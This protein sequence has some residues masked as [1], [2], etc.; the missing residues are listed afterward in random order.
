MAGRLGAR[1]DV[2]NA[3]STLLID[4]RIATK[5]AGISPVCGQVPA[6]LRIA[7]VIAMSSPQLAC[8][9]GHKGQTNSRAGA[10]PMTTN[11]GGMRLRLAAVQHVVIAART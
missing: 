5:R 6:V 2:I 1:P 3:N 10:A 7:R 9:S 11:N 8:T 4:N